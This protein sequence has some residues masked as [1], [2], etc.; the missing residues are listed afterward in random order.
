MGLIAPYN[1]LTYPG[2]RPGF[3]PRHFIL[4]QF[5]TPAAGQ[6]FRGS[7]A[8]AGS[9]FVRLDASSGPPTVTGAFTSTVDPVL[10]QCINQ[11]TTGATKW[12]GIA[13]GSILA[14]TVGL[15]W[16]AI[17]RCA[18][19]NG[20]TR[21]VLLVESNGSAT[22]LVILN[23]TIGLQD[24]NSFFSSTMAMTV[25]VPYFVCAS[26]T[27]NPAGTGFMALTNL[28]TGQVTTQSIGGWTIGS[29]TNNTTILIFGDGGART[30]CGNFA[31]GVVLR[32]FTPQAQLLKWAAD[33]WSFW[34]PPTV[35]NI[36][37]SGVPG[38]SSFSAAEIRRTRAI[39]GTRTG[40]RQVIR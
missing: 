31:A 32:I 19:T 16:G 22:G 2:G 25:G 14:N 9:S 13:V 40:S 3:D 33:P 15:T 12:Q 5:N 4:Q 10:G 20:G 30:F 18:S 35:R 36:L 38:P 8:A 37:F 34:Y 27:F 26:C 7:I 28:S 1:R 23:S 29:G 17:F 24:T 11:V 6:V 39:T 21:Q